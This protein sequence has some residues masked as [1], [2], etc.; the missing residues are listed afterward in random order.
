MDRKKL[1]TLANAAVEVAI[2]A[3]LTRNLGRDGTS[4]V[5]GPVAAAILA[6]ALAE[7]NSADIKIALLGRENA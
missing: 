3:G 6:A 5:A 2:R 1:Q 4:T 7:T